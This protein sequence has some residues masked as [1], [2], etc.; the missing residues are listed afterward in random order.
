MILAPEITSCKPLR[1]LVVKISLGFV[2]GLDLD[3]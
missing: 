3:M 2:V 1:T